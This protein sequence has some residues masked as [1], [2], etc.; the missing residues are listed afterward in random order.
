[1]SS[2]QSRTTIAPALPPGVSPAEKRMIGRFEVLGELG[3]GGMGIVYLARDSRLQRLVAIKVITDELKCDPIRESFFEDEARLASRLIHQNL[4]IV[5]DAGRHENDPFIVMEYVRG[6]PLHLQIPNGR[7]LGIPESLDIGRQ[8]AEA[9]HFM[10]TRQVIHRDLKPGNVMVTDEDLV[11]IL[12]FGLARKTIETDAD[13]TR[14]GVAIGTPGYMAPEQCTG[15]HID[16][17]ADVFAFGCILFEC[18]TGRPAFECTGL[19]DYLR[20]LNGTGPDFSSLPPGTPREVVDLLRA[21]MMHDR[22][23]RPTGFER[24]LEVLKDIGKATAITSATPRSNVP[25]EISRFIGRDAELERLR[26]DIGQHRLVTLKGM[27]GVGK[28]R[29]ALELAQSMRSDFPDGTWFVDLSPL[30][31]D[32]RVAEAVAS[33]L[34]HACT[35]SD[36]SALADTGML[37]I[38]DNCEHLPEAAARCARALLQ[39]GPEVRVLA[40]SRVP[41]GLRGERIFEVPLLPCPA[42]EATC[43]DIGTSEAVR[44]FNDRASLVMDDFDPDDTELTLIAHICRQLEGVPLAIE[45]AAAGLATMPP[46]KLVRHIDESLCFGEQVGAYD[47]PDRHRTLEAAIGWSETQLN[48]AERTLFRRLSVFRGGWTLEAA[49]HVCTDQKDDSEDVIDDARI[50]ALL[51]QLLRRS[52]VVFER[53]RRG[54]SYRFLESVRTYARQVLLRDEGEEG[55]QRLRERHLH[56]YLGVA[57]EAAEG[58]RSSEQPAWLALLDTESD[59]ILAALRTAGRRDDLTSER[60][61]LAT[62]LHRY[63]YLRGRASEGLEQLGA[64]IDAASGATLEERA[65]SHNG[66]GILAWET[67]RDDDASRH[68]ELALELWREVGVQDRIAGVLTNLGMVRQEQERFD[69][70]RACQEEA[71]RLYESEKNEYGAACARL[72]LGALFLRLDMFTE[73]REIFEQCQSVF[74]SQRDGLRLG[75]TH[76]NIGATWYETGEAAAAI[77]HFA[78]ALR[79]FYVIRYEY[80]M[81]LT[82]SCIGKAQARLGHPKRAARIMA[83]A[84]GLW[85]LLGTS[86]PA[87]GKEDYAQ[88]LRTLEETLGADQFKAISNSAGGPETIRAAVEKFVLNIGSMSE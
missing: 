6:T 47:R 13:G 87:D 77:P 5:F 86:V 26:A 29:M 2:F 41:L 51:K 43:L 7:G 35:P 14:T 21:C 25:H 82:L 23:H 18:L 3:R 9:L 81:A 22:E 19:A 71:I 24:A 36:W 79:E 38:L 50:G 20:R 57:E 85:N 30:R 33:V 34:P 31:E 88:I 28:T 58:L 40:T 27:G 42:Q 64:A 53:E 73:A 69:D 52:L 74:E 32:E 37:L 83:W 45:L 61:R 62:A 10:H 16:A 65:A 84:D 46:A 44:L 8:M 75:M 55:T 63:W 67:A 60:L 56:H 11:K 68:C 80:G 70:A 15:E 54:G 66:M 59:N 72:N 76:H 1:M 49:R 12:D 48:D 17:R 78:R 39:A 4:C